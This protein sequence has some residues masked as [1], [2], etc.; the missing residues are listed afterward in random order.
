MNFEFELNK[1]YKHPW[2]LREKTLSFICLAGLQA[3]LELAD[4]L[5]AVDSTQHISPDQYSWP[6]YTEQFIPYQNT[7]NLKVQVVWL[8]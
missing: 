2:K 5:C 8:V 4:S 1:V 3:S 6:T 7:F